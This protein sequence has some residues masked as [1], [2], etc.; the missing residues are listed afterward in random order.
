MN[1]SELIDYVAQKADI[2]KTA[3]STAINSVF[4]AIMHELK[5]GKEFVKVGF[6]RFRVR[7]RAA[8]EGRNPQTGATIKIK[9]RKVA[10]FKAGKLLS[11]A[12]QE[13]SHK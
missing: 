13:G 3:A 6:G 10:V 5:T 12:V 7:E 1:N 9:A 4:D 11:D 2:S 8:R